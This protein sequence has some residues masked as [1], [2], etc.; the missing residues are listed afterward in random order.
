M[1]CF[2]SLEKRFFEVNAIHLVEEPYRKNYYR[3]S[4]RLNFF[5]SD[6]NLDQTKYMRQLCLRKITNLMTSHNMW[7]DHHSFYVIEYEVRLVARKNNDLIQHNLE[8]KGDESSDTESVS[9]M[10][11]NSSLSEGDSAYGSTPSDTD[12]LFA[13]LRYW[14]DGSN[15]NF[16]SGESSMS[17]D[18]E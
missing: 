17:N 5:E 7:Q 18:D 9:T 1:L 3:I 13:N 11:V 4:L 12:S 8:E 14:S 6:V 15:E 16:D 2:N 10:S